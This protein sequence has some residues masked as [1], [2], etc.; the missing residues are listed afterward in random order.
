M[1]TDFNKIALKLSG[2]LTVELHEDVQDVVAPDQVEVEL[3]ELE[4][5]SVLRGARRSSRIKVV[6][7]DQAEA[8]PLPASP[9]TLKIKGPKSKGPVK[10]CLC[11]IPETDDKGS[12]WL[13]CENCENWFHPKCVGLPVARAKKIA[14]TG[15]NRIS[16]GALTHNINSLDFLPTYLIKDTNLV[17]G[18]SISS[19]KSNLTVPLISTGQ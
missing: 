12:F 13:G 16:I 2:V 15:V 14:E 8:A 11:Q 5:S 1:L 6:A 19:S 18:D 7:K 4:E 17:G 9:M 10:Y 3:E